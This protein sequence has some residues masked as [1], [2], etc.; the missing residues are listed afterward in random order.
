MR[1]SSL[2]DCGKL[3]TDSNG[4]VRCG[5]DLVNDADADPTNELQRL[6]KSG[7]Q[8]CLSNGGGCVDA[9]GEDEIYQNWIFGGMYTDTAHPN[10]DRINPFTGSLSCP[11][12]F[13]AYEIYYDWY[14]WGYCPGHMR[15]Y[16]CLKRA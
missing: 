2:R 10:C 7:N 15:L 8:I 12:G 1:L 11:P 4:N 3:Y 16:I 9:G 14:R 6:S 13:N 5:S